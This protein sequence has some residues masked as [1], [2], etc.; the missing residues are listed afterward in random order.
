[1]SNYNSLKATIDANIRQNNNE[2]ITGLIL[3]SVLKDMTD[4]LGAGFQYMGMATPTTNPGSP[5]QNVFYLASGVGSYT[6]FG[7]T[8]SVSG[9][10]AFVWNG[11]W[12]MQMVATFTNDL[13][14]GIVSEDGLFFVDQ[15]LNIGVKITSEGLIAN[16]TLTIQPL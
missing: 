9:V 2:E 11:A 13:E 3:N 12:T 4:S 10:Y 1:M 16:N 14:T 15:A 7:L 6:H 8:I 5:D